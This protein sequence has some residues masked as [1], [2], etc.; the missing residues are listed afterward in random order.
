[1]RASW[2][3]WFLFGIG[4]WCSLVRFRRRRRC[5][6]TAGG[7]SSSRR[8]DARTCAFRPE[9]CL[10][11]VCL[12]RIQDLLT[13]ILDVL[14]RDAAFYIVLYLVKWQLLL[15]IDAIDHVSDGIGHN[16][17]DFAGLQGKYLLLL[18]RRHGSATL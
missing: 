3:P 17:G 2:K 4:R 11:V 9:V 18:S 5:R 12:A 10:V 6:R 16:L 8:T 15:G 7:R 14:L 1:M 13:Y